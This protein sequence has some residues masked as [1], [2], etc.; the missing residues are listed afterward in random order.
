MTIVVEWDATVERLIYITFPEHWSWDDFYIAVQQ[1]RTMIASQAVDII[2]DMS[3][4]TTLPPNVL[5]QAQVVLQTSTSN[6][7]II[8]VV[9]IHPTI[10]VTFNMFKRIFNNMLYRTVRELHMVSVQQQAYSLLENYRAQI[11]QAN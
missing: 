1:C 9:G 5:T 3:A 8:V 7:G 4:S 6:I 11:A 2:V 10:R